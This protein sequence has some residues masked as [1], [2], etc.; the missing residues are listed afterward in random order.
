MSFAAVLVRRDRDRLAP[1]AVSALCV[2]LTAVPWQLVNAAHDLHDRDVAPS[3]AHL[4]ELGFVLHR[5]GRLLVAQAYLWAMPIALVAVVVMLVR[6][7]DRQLAVGVLA[8]ELALVAALV[9]VYVSGT[10][11]VEYLV[12][13]WSGERF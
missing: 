1:L 2:G 3:Q 6:G 7:R 4:D 9:F 10:T 13:R 8:L 12:R 11:G 5:I